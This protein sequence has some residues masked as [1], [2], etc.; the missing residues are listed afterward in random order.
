MNRREF[1]R[2]AVGAL[3]LPG[4]DSHG[5]PKT[6][7]HVSIPPFDA[8]RF[9]SLL[10]ELRLAYEAIGHHVSPTL[11]PG[12]Q[13]DAIRARC[14]WFPTDLPGELLALYGWRDGQKGDACHNDYPFW[15]RDCTLSSLEVA[16][17]EY[18]SIMQS[19]GRYP[20][21]H[22]TLKY[23]FPFAAFNGGWMVLPCDGH[24]LYRAYKRPVIFVLQGID[25]YFYSIELM[26]RTC[27]D[28]VRAGKSEDGVIRFSEDLEMKI[29]QQHNP[30]IQEV[31][32]HDA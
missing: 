21:D 26:V 17:F 32:Q 13:P 12:L 2:G 30:G 4:C 22:E 25:I 9:S 31:W 11:R 19:Y 28:W 5:G 18:Q 7:E 29:W 23:S 14:K 15:I 20:K 10:E 3:L 1:C 24:T 16:E 8:V 27:I 6:L